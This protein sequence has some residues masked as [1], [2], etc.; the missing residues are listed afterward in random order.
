VVVD[1][2]PAQIARRAARVRAGW[3]EAERC[4]RLRPD[5]RPLAWRVPLV[6]DGLL[7]AVL[8]GA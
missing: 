5:L 4:R 2:S 8:A 6:D 7:A 3:S 1:P